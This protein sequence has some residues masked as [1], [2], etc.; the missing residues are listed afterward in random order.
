MLIIKKT[1]LRVNER[2]S[3]PVVTGSLD[4]LAEKV[5]Y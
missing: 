2:L 5:D 3:W 1:G 4:R